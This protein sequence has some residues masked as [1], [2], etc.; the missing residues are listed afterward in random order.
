ME[1]DLDPELRRVPIGVVALLLPSILKGCIG[2]SPESAAFGRRLLRYPRTFQSLGWFVGTVG[3]VGL[4]GSQL[5]VENTE[6]RACAI[7]FGVLILL[8]LLPVRMGRRCSVSYTEEEVR[9]CPL[10]G[11]PFFFGWKA[12]VDAE[13]SF[14][15][16]WWIFRLADGRKV[17]VS[18]YMVGHRDFIHT[19]RRQAKVFIPDSDLPVRI[20]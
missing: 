4:F 16:N 6:R 20:G 3:F 11:E 7:T 12:I 19:A 13:Y 17:R 9:F 2:G 18:P 14:W 8:G 5:S 15:A 1:L 10:F